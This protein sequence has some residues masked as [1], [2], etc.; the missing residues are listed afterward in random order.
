MS[1]LLFPEIAEES[2]M[3]VDFQPPESQLSEGILN[4]LRQL[5]ESSLPPAAASTPTPTSTQ[6][7]SQDPPRPASV[8]MQEPT[9]PPQS[10]WDQLHMEKIKEIYEGMLDTYPNTVRTPPVLLLLEYCRLTRV[11]SSPYLWHFLDDPSHFGYAEQLFKKF[12]LKTSPSVD[13]LKFYLTYIGR[14]TT[15]PNAHDVICKS[16]DFALGHA[17]Q[18]KGSYENWQ[19][20]F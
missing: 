8:T 12:L 19:D 18:E 10:H 1:E 15:S 5:P 13:L 2:A 11:R 3:Q 4:A 9:P 20:T 7:N 16:Y 14:I 17:G 6:P